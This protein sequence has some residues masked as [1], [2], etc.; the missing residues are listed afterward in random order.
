MFFCPQ[1]LQNLAV[2]KIV[3]PQAL[4][5]TVADLR[6]VVETITDF[7]IWYNFLVRKGFSYVQALTILVLSVTILTSI[8]AV[9][10]PTI[11]RAIFAAQNINNI[12]SV[13]SVL[14]TMAEDVHY[15]TNVSA[16]G[17]S[18]RVTRQGEQYQ[19]LVH[20]QRLARKK[21]S[22]LYLTPKELNVDKLTCVWLK[23]GVL[24][25]TVSSSAGEFSR[26]CATRNP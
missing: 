8:L 18:F 13:V 23:P 4:Q 25:I 17:D 6:R 2:C 15:G 14:D 11:R 22:Y 10:F 7:S 24:S 9:V 16:E 1:K 12:Q 3:L 5:V 26:F 19:Y 21:L 20:N